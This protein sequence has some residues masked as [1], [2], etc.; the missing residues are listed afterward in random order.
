MKFRR[1]LIFLVGVS[2]TFNH[3]AILPNTSIGLLSS[4]LYILSMLSYIR[5]WKSLGL[6]YGKAIWSIPIFILIFSFINLANICGYN[7]PVFPFTMFMCFLLMLFQLIHGL[8]DRMAMSYC[9]YGI[10]FGGV[11]MS[12]F[13]VLD[14]GVEF[15]LD[16]RLIMFGENS[17]ELGIYMGLSSVVI[18][19]DIILNHEFQL[20]KLRFL[21]LLIFLP[22]VN[23]LLATGSR[24]AFL[25]FA[26][27]VI[28]IIV[29]Y[30]T[31]SMSGKIVFMVIGIV[32]CCYAMINFISSDSVLLG[33]LMNT[34]ED[35]NTS[36]RENITESLIPYVLRSPIYGYGQTGYVEVARSA[37][38]RI[39][40]IGGVTYGYSP[41]NVIME[42][43]LYTG[44]I[45]LFFWL[46]FWWQIAKKSWFLFWN[47]R[48]IMSGLM[49]IP[50][51]ACIL[52][53]QLLGAKWAYILYAYILT[54][55][56]YCKHSQLD[57]L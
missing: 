18:L 10:A 38:R 57:M 5:H 43:L 23:L 13:Y 6:Y 31:N 2:M 7:T 56:Y 24:T 44:I 9:M 48:L 45:G 8:Y 29:F 32:C 19:N 26:L 35:G 1:L 14:I 36:G 47:S 49:C 51:L 46:K 39:S 22:I 12:I 52:S 37:L 21:F 34:V 41:H 16:Y 40:V 50:L 28:L 15:D 54:E 42:L 3:V 17:N 30:P 20:N 53:G 55:Y 11:L 4:A 33:R 27:S 25:I